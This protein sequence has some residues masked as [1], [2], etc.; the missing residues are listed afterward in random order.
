[1]DTFKYLKS[2]IKNCFNFRE[3]NKNCENILLK[4]K[5]YRICLQEHPEYVLRQYGGYCY[6]CATSIGPLKFGEK[7]KEECPICFENKELIGIFCGKHELCISCWI[8]IVE[9]D[10]VCPFCRKHLFDI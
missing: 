2:S 9:T 8:R 10:S 4:C 6:N 3:S 7:C 1:M 5:N